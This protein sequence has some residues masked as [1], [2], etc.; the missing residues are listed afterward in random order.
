MTEERKSRYDLWLEEEERNNQPTK[1]CTKCHKVK[2][3]GEFHRQKNG[4]LGRYS[5][6]KACVSSRNRKY[7][8][9][10]DRFWKRYHSLTRPNGACVD[11]VGS[12]DWQGI[13]KCTY[14]GKDT[15]LRR[16]M[17]RLVFGEVADDEVITTTCRNKKCVRHSHLKKITREEHEAN[18]ANSAA[19]GDRNGLRA[20]PERAARGD[21]SG[22]RLYPERRPRGE[23]HKQAKLTTDDVYTI[24]ALCG[25]GTP[26]TV[27]AQKYGVDPS[28]IGKI[29][30]GR[31]WAHVQ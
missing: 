12:C 30:R 13:P 19:T 5:I 10:E 14:G 1:E 2:T 8:S 18:R 6:C 9:R 17:Y 31:L 16:V 28:T 26:H 11:W 3:L 15:H 20:H 27:V 21:K 24:R 29:V 23:N 25:Q 4:K 7:K 22:A